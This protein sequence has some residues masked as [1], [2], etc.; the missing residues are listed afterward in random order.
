MTTEV[1]DTPAGHRIRRQRVRSGLA[2]A[3]VVALAISASACGGGG[4]SPGVASLGPTTTTSPAGAAQGGNKATDY[5]DAVKYAQCMRTK[6]IANF[7]DP[8]SNGNFIQQRGALN[9][10]K[11]DTGSSAYRKAD[12]SC[13]HLL[14]NGGQLTPAEQQQ[15]LA[16]AL[17]LVQC[18]RSHG[19]PNMADPSTSGGGVAIRFP[20][21]AGPNSPTFQKAMTT[22]RKIVPAL[23]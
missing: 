9:G 22:C 11:V 20:G 18:L 23:P 10:Q 3:A 7:P 19:F 2:V 16:N 15:M 5:V 13:S 17:K 6:G 4:G 8:N 21:G 12:A 1:C 14:P